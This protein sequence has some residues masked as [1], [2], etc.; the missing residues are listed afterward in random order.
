MV[1][2]SALV[3]S[4]RYALVISYRYALVISYRW[5]S[6]W[7][8][9]HCPRPHPRNGAPGDG[10]L[11]HTG[12]IATYYQSRALVLAIVVFEVGFMARKKYPFIGAFV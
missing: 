4:Y 1:T 2:M 6:G 5:I 3:I 9:L 10:T 11:S 7:E 12:Q 8:S